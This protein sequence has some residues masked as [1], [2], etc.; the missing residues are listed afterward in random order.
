MSSEAQQQQQQHSS[1]GKYRSN[2]SSHR[3]AP[4]P[5]LYN[6]YQNIDSTT[7]MQE[8]AILLCRRTPPTLNGGQL[9]NSAASSK[10]L[11]LNIYSMR[12]FKNKII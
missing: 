9:P 11:Y 10:F 6:N 1:I 5:S 2:G 7:S 8:N 4:Y 12:C 3:T